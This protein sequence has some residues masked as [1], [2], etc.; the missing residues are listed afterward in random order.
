MSID[1][2][3]QK[4]CMRLGI[5]RLCHFTPSRNLAHIIAGKIGVLA[6]EHLEKSERKVFNA[7]D[8]KRYDGYKSHICC[9]IEYPNVWY[10]S[11][12]IENEKLFKDWVILLIKPYYLWMKGTLYC[13]RNAS[14]EYGRY[15]GGGF[16][17]FKLLY[18]DVIIGSGGRIYK[19][20]RTH[21]TACPT[22]NQAEVLVSD[23]INLSDITGIVTRNERQA[24]NE[25]CRLKLQELKAIVNFYVVSEFYDKHAMSLAISNGARPKE[26]L[27]NGGDRHD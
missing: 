25:I 10:L 15:I 9:S 27:F 21:L 1:L 12:K 8:L 22:D 18:Q 4:E 20:S 11:H 6:T 26:S 14:A 3:I 24:R 13:H 7:T 2:Q 5:S 16:E 19:R 17:S 23:C